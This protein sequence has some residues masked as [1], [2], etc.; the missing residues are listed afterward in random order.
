M[1][2]APFLQLSTDAL[3]RLTEISN[4]CLE[5]GKARWA[6]ALERQAKMLDKLA[7]GPS[8]SDSEGEGDASSK[9]TEAS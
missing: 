3:A 9:G 6:A 8:S 1:D 4:Q 7:E 5:E 2:P